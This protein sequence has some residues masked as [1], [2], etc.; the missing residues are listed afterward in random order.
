MCLLDIKSS[1]FWDISQCGPLKV[2][3]RFGGICRFH[4]QGRRI[5]QAR[6]HRDTL[7]N[8]SLMLKMEATCSP[9]KSVDFQR[10]T[11]RYIREDGNLITTAVRT[12]TSMDMFIRSVDLSFTYICNRGYNKRKCV[13]WDITNPNGLAVSLLKT[14]MCCCKANNKYRFDNVKQNI[15]PALIN[16]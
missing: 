10:T 8:Y 7:L 11:L 16:L 2:N 1:I 4:F 9:E 13:L 12:P 3:R 14:K 6:K 15:S 5:S